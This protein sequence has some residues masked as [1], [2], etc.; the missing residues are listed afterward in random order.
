MDI[1]RSLLLAI[2]FFSGFFLWQAWQAEHAP[3][4]VAAKVEAPASA[5]PGAPAKELPA[6]SATPAASGPAAGVPPP[7]G[8]PVTGGQTV[9]VKTDL[10]TAEVDPVGGVI[11]LIS[12]NKHSDAT[13]HT[14]PYHVL[15]RTPERVFV[16]QAGL[17]GAGLP[18]HQTKYELL[19]GPRELPPGA[20][21]VDLRLAT[22]TPNGDVVVDFEIVR[23]TCD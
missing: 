18:N 1:R 12:L 22:T 5:Q 2:F 23:V 19:P 21:R 4:P 17:I 6:P 16:A 3:P 14:K 8:A 7:T 15:Q 13:D 9:T 10:Y 20:E 11:A